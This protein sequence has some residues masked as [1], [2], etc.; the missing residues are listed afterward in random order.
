MWPNGWLTAWLDGCLSGLRACWL[1]KP[2]VHWPGLWLDAWL[3]GHPPAGVLVSIPSLRSWPSELADFLFL[4]L[5]NIR[6]REREEKRDGVKERR[7][8]RDAKQR[9]L[10]GRL[11]G[12]QASLWPDG[13][14]PIGSHLV[15]C[16][17]G[18][19][20]GRGDGLALQA[21]LGSLTSVLRGARLG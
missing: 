19:L 2:L 11:V 9:L 16:P 7:R 20:I 10:G 15:G 21:W 8:E 17:Y 14:W 6:E 12:W 4:D 5:Q 18:W 3:L 1:A 13:W